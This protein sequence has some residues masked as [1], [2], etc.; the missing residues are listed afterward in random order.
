MMRLDR[1]TMSI[2]PMIYEASSVAYAP[3][4]SYASR[5]SHDYRDSHD[6]FDDHD[7]HIEMKNKKVL[8]KK[9]LKR[10]N[11]KV[12]AIRKKTDVSRTSRSSVIH[13]KDNEASSKM[14]MKTNIPSFGDYD[15]DSDDDDSDD[16]VIY[17]EINDNEHDDDTST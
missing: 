2:I 1:L 17:D 8:Q 15:D 10:M 16:A 5:S 12:K 9:R 6:H 13:K 4:S 7:Y 3:R 11:K 14:K